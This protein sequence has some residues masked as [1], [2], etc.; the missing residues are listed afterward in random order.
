MCEK[1]LF[2]PPI[3]TA[4]SGCQCHSPQPADFISMLA[5]KLCLHLNHM[6]Y[7]INTYNNDAM[8]PEHRSSIY[9]LSQADDFLEYETKYECRSP[10]FE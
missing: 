9:F 1:K 10:T 4:V 7:A 3:R 2:Y 5:V 8:R 6:T